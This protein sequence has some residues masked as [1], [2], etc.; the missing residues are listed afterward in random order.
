MA[1]SPGNPRDQGFPRPDL[2][3][4]FDD[5]T[6]EHLEQRGHLPPPSLQVTGSPRLDAI[7]ASARAMDDTG[8]AALRRALGA[9]GTS[10][11]V[12]VAAKFTQLGSAF[13]ALVS[14]AR[15]M[16]DVRLV[17]KPHPAE[18]SAPY[19]AAA[20]GTPN[21]VLAPADAD[22]GRLAAVADAL[23]TANSTAAIEAMPLGVPALVV[24]LPNNL[25]PFVEAG[26]MAGA[27]TEAD[28]EPVLRAL[29]YDREMRQRL[30]V[31]R[32]AF[33]ARYRYTADGGAASRAAEAIIALSRK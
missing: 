28:V 9:G 11:L 23:V 20:S 8:R 3:L 5:F 31:A 1:P 13:E 22:L 24:A 6:R 2:S 14:A 21:V 25:S 4:L 30:S 16:P 17:V 27:W 7:V 26:V 15:A 10:P 18:A 33:L 19:V 12:V 32:E 29:L